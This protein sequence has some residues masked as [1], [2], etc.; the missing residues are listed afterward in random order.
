M[1]PLNY[2]FRILGSVVSI[3]TFLC[4]LRIILTWIPSLSYSPFTR[5]IAN[6]TDPYLNLF[7]GIRWLVI[8]SFDFS[9]AVALC[10]LSVIST[11]L[12]N[13]SH[14]GKITIG[15]LLGMLV[16]MAWSIISSIIGFIILL[17]IV[18]LIVL[19]VQK[20]SYPSPMME[21]LDRTLYKIVYNIVR[22]FVGKNRITYKSALIATSIILFLVNAAGTFAITRLANF[23]AYLPF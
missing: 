22:P 1:S 9:P 2:I 13:F 5:F 14:G 17:L 12:D 4:F 6:I 20:N 16:Q 10:L 7:R 18:R 19:L 15:M 21:S 3:Y 23:I 8:G 11:I